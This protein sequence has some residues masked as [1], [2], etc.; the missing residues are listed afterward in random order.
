MPKATMGTSD[1][2]EISITLIEAEKGER[3]SK[4]VITLVATGNGQHVGI[5]SVNAIAEE[6][7]FA[8]SEIALNHPF[9][10]NVSNV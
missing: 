1:C 3:R 5:G 10:S 6:R 2:W 9:L 4:L 8:S 7:E